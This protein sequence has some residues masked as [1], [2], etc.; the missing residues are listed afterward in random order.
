MVIMSIED[1]IG[2]GNPLKEG[3]IQVKVEGHLIEGET[4]IE[5]LLKKDIPIEMEGLP[6][7]EDI[8]EE[9]PLKME[10]PL[11]M[12]DPWWMRTTGPSRTPW[13]S[14]NYNNPDSSS[15]TGYICLREYIWFSG[16]IYA[17]VSL[18]ARPNQ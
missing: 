17:A 6:E 18:G 7:E 2:I 1:H 10:D 16:T 3:G 9:E 5:E 14:D 13:A 12:E 8:L 11:E 15:D 4:Q